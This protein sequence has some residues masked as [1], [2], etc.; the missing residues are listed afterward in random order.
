MPVTTVS[1]EKDMP[2]RE[3]LDHVPRNAGDG[4]NKEQC[5]FRFGDFGEFD[6]DADAYR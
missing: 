2:D 3:W 4:F 5:M 1:R 6:A